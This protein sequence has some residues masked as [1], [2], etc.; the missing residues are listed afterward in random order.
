ME[1]S[2]SSKRSAC[3]ECGFRISLKKLPSVAFLL[4]ATK[5]ETLATSCNHDIASSFSG[6][7]GAA[8]ESEEKGFPL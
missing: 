4:T 7:L 8:N 6:L 5:F 2:T 3:Q 1:T